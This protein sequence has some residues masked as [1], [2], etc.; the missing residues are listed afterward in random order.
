MRFVEGDLAPPPELLDQVMALRRSDASTN[1]FAPLDALYA[2]ILNSSPNP[3]LTVDWLNIIFRYGFLISPSYKSWSMRFVQLFLESSPGEASYVFRGLNSLVR[4]PP[5][6]DHTS[7][8][9]LFHKSVT[10][11]LKDP[12]RW[13]DLYVNDS[14]SLYRSRYL[15]IWKGTCVFLFDRSPSLNPCRLQTRAQQRLLVHSKALIF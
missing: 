11:F 15:Q 10:E 4:I 9:S 6:D 5:T 8:Y 7:P 2:H 1:P 12:L 3:L 14:R 13:R